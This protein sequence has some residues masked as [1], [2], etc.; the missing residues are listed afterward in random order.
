[1]EL[2]L[3]NLKPVKGANLLLYYFWDEADE[4][5]KASLP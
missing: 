2:A 4:S 5:R 1:M 3:N